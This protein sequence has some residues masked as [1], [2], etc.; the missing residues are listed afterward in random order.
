MEKAEITFKFVTPCIM[1]GAKQKE[2]E[3]RVP[4]VRGALRWWHEAMGYPSAY[5]IF[6]GVNGCVEDRKAAW[7]SSLIIRE[8]SDTPPFKTLDAMDITKNKF[9]YFLWPLRRTQDA[10]GVIAENTQITISMST[11]RGGYLTYD[12]VIKAFLL[13]GSL[14]TRSRRCY[15]SVWPVKAV[16]D[17]EEW[18]IPETEDEFISEL[19]SFM[20]SDSQ[21]RVIK[22]ASPCRDGRQ[23]I[24]KCADFLKSFRCGS[25]KSG[26]PSTWGKNDHDVIKGES[27]VY[28]QALGLPLTQRYSNNYGT[29]ESE[30][31]GYDRLASPI[32]FK[33]IPLKEGF[34][35]VAI[36]F[37]SHSMEN[38][39]TVTL[40]GKGTHNRTAIL[41]N[42][43]LCTIAT[44][45][46]IDHSS[47][48]TE[49]ALIADFSG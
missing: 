25:N 45:E 12:Q 34:L 35:P 33:V 6:G 27:T 40:K 4:S 19:E 28:R 7:K 14:G 21:C 8:L 31:E 49:S 30:V 42:D 16:I 23:A 41:D 26:K 32:H 10:R 48:W 5:E 17:G 2:A 11:R 39:T 3:M 29:L 13:L 20:D 22:V 9:D 44:P 15:G 18:K 37:L 46:H 24:N 36:V 38:G 1:A 47:V 43:L